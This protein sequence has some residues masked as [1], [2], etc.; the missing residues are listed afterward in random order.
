MMRCWSWAST[1]QLGLAQVRRPLI[2]G[3][4]GLSARSLPRTVRVVSPFMF[5]AI[6]RAMQNLPDHFQ[7]RRL[8]QVG[9]LQ[10]VQELFG[11]PFDL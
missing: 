2:N 1:F 3:L 4:T 8:L 6:M 10:Y 5:H 7:T 9:Y 11:S